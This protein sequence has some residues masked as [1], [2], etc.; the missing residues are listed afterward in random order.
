[1]NPTVSR[2]H[3][4]ED[5]YRTIY[6]GR[7][8]GLRIAL[9]LERSPIEFS[10][11]LLQP[12]Y[13]DEASRIAASLLPVHKG[14]NV[15]DMCAAPGGKSLVLAAKLAGSGMLICND[16]SSQRRSRLIKVLDDHLPN[17]FRSIV[18]ISSHDATRWGLYEQEVYDSILLDAPCSSERHVLMDPTAL[19]QWGPA[20]TKHLAIQQFAMLAAALEAVRIGGNILY[21]TCSISPMENEEVIQKLHKKRSGR[22]EEISCDVE[23]SEK[24]SHGQII[25]PDVSKGMGPLFF[26]LI[27]RLS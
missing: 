27:R 1:M 25:L 15:L 5:Y 22:F 24:L 14:D 17:D 9:Q 8:T 6:G 23:P 16:R 19:A 7:W 11:G 13:L 4:F 18:T 20:R 21:C 26:C 2:E 3:R 12:Y 10:Q